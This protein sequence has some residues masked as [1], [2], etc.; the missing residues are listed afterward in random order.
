MTSDYLIFWVLFIVFLTED[1]TFID[2][3]DFEP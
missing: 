2:Y 1:C 3:L